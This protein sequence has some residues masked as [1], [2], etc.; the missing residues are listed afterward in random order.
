MTTDAND[1]V[2]ARPGRDELE[3]RVRSLEAGMEEDA[4]KHGK[5]LREARE[6]RDELAAEARVLR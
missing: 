3:A 4:N 1:R 6:A 2:S 5:A